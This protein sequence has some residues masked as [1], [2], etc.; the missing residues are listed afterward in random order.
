MRSESNKEKDYSQDF[1]PH[2][3]HRDIRHGS[4]ADRYC[5]GLIPSVIMRQTIPPR[6]G[7]WVQGQR[8]HCQ[9][10]WAGT[11]IGVLVFE[12]DPAAAAAESRGRLEVTPQESYLWLSPWLPTDSG[13]RSEWKTHLQA[14]LKCYVG[15]SVFTFVCLWIR[16][17]QSW[18]RGWGI[19]KGA[20]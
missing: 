9:Q 20:S 4:W 18:W 3:Q 2:S 13:F 8:L 1:Q 12:V 6:A 15:G 19:A 16:P 10:N 5:C 14:G 17:D 11:L 7:V